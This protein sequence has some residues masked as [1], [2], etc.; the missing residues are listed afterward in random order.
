[1]KQTERLDCAPRY[2]IM[3]GVWILGAFANRS[4]RQN[5]ALPADEAV[6]QVCRVLNGEIFAGTAAPQEIGETRLEAL[7]QTHGR[8]TRGPIPTTGDGR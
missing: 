1:M 8:G 3:L 5:I 2:G 6:C 7:L 4:G